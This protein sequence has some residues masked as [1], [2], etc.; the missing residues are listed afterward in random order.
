AA[1]RRLL[2]DEVRGH[3]RYAVSSGAPLPLRDLVGLYARVAGK[4]LPI[5]WGKRAYRRREVMVPW[6]RGT[7]LPGWAPAVSLEE[8]IRRTLTATPGPRPA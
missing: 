4:P 5:E 8:G 2:A 1:A 3:E 7:P 6:R